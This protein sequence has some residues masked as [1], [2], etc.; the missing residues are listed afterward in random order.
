M[1]LRNRL[2][3]KATSRS[4]A[5][6]PKPFAM[7][8]NWNRAEDAVQCV[9]SLLQGNPGVEVLT[10]D[11]GSE[12]GSVEVLLSKFPEPAI[13]ENTWNMVYVKGVN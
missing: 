5:T 10:V 11:N 4:L 2:K 7:T 8:M 1:Q 13:L 6:S 3:R 9:S 12:D